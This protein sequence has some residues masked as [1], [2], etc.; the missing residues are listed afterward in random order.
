MYVALS[1]RWGIQKKKKLRTLEG[2]LDDDLERIRVEELSQTFKEALEV[3]RN[4]GANYLWIDSLCIIQDSS[5]D[6]A[7]EATQM[8]KIFEKAYCA[9]AAVDAIDDETGIDRG[10]FLPREEDPLTVHFKCA[11]QKDSVHPE[12]FR[13]ENGQPY[14][15]KYTYYQPSPAENDDVYNEALPEQHRMVAKPRLLGSAGEITRSKWNWRGWIL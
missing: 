3:T 1:H 15:W 14:R 4:L 5:D 9:I 13:S 7:Y 2:N 11:P 6:W 10:L 12:R 8:G